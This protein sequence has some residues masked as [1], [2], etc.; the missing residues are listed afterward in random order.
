MRQERTGLAYHV[1]RCIEVE[2]GYPA[3]PVPSDAI[4][5]NALGRII[6]SSFGDAVDGLRE[7]VRVLHKYASHLDSLEVVDRLAGTL[8]LLAIS[9]RP[10]L[11]APDTGITALLE[12]L[13]IPASLHGLAALRDAILK[14]THLNLELTPAI[15][16]G[17]REHAAWES[18]LRGHQEKCLKWREHSR[19]ANL[20]YAPATHV[21]RR[22]LDTG[23]AL[24]APFD[25]IIQDQRSRIADVR[26]AME[27]WSSTRH[28]D[29][30]IT[31]T[32]RDIRGRGAELRPIEDLARTVLQKRVKEATDLFAA[33]ISLLEQE[34]RLGTDFRYKRASECR[35]EVIACLEKAELSAR[36]AREI[37]GN[38][39]L[40]IEVASKGVID[41]IVDLRN[42]FDPDASLIPDRHPREVLCKEL[43]AIPSLALDA[44]WN[45]PQSINVAD[46]LDLLL[47]HIESGPINWDRAFFDQLR[48]GN[49]DATER[50]L[51][52]IE[53]RKDASDDMDRLHREQER[54]IG[55]S[56]ARLGASLKMTRAAIERAIAEDLFA[57]SELI[58][59]RSIVDTV[60][61]EEVRNFA[62][63]EQQLQQV[64]T[65]IEYR[66]Q[67]R[68]DEVRERLRNN[69]VTIDLS[70]IEQALAKGNLLAANEYIAMIERGE[71]IQD[72]EPERDAFREFFPATAMAIQQFLTRE[73][74]TKREVVR[75]LGRRESV[76]P[77]D[78]TDVAEE[79]A[80][81]AKRMLAAWI[82]ASNYE[83]ADPAGQTRNALVELLQTLG[84]RNVQVSSV[85]A[86]A[87]EKAR[88]Y[89][90]QADPIVEQRTCVIPHYGSLAG[91]RYR[92][93]CVWKRPSEEELVDLA[94]SMHQHDR[95]LLV[96]Y[97]GN[98]SESRRRSLALLCKQ[99]P[100]SFLLVDENLIFFLATE[101]GLR[102]PSLFS[103]TFPFT[104]ADPYTTT[105]GLVPFEMFFGRRSERASVFEP[106]GT[107]LV[108]GGR[109]LGKT[110]LLRD[111]ERRHH[112]QAKG[113]IVRWIDLKAEGIGLNRPIGDLWV[114]IASVLNQEKVL[115]RHEFKP[116]GLGKAIEEWL[117]QDAKRRIVLLLDESDAFLK[118]DAETRVGPSHDAFSNLWRLKGIMDKTSRRFKVVFAGL[119]N[120]QRTSRDVN[121]PL[122]HLGAPICIGPLLGS[123]EWQEA[124]RMVT[125]PFSQLGYQFDATEDL[126]TRILALANWYPS[127]IQLFCKHLLEHLT[128]PNRPSFSVQSCP[129][130]VI[131]AKHIEDAYQ[132]QELRKAIVDRFR[133]TLDLDPRYR[134]IALVIALECATQRDGFIAGFSVQ[135]IREQALS[136]WEAGFR[137]TSS[138]EGLR[139]ILDEMIGLGVLRKVAGSNY[140]LRSPNVVNLL[141]TKEEIEHALIDATLHQPPPEYEASTFRRA[142]PGNANK[143]SPLTAKQESDLVVPSHGVSV[144]FGSKLA[145]LLDMLQVLRDASSAHKFD[146]DDAWDAVKSPEMFR[147]ML[148]ARTER[149]E[150]GLVV[151]VVPISCP[152]DIQWVIAAAEKLRSLKSTT[153]LVRVIFLAD[154]KKAWSWVQQ[155]T[156]KRER[157]NALGVSEMSLTPWHENAIRR[158][159]IDAGLGPGGG[160]GAE[161]FARATGSWGEILHEAASRC[162]KGLHQ[163]EKHLDDFEASIVTSRELLDRFEIRE[164]S[165][166][167]LKVLADM[168][169]ELNLDG[170]V[171]LLGDAEPGDLRQVMDWAELLSYVTRTGVNQWRIDHMVGHLLQRCPT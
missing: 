15:L 139:T 133:W 126:P 67:L 97:F 70:L 71:T 62:T 85:D 140:A 5:A 28:I 27:V 91:G 95:P 41:T 57:E 142:L 10:A 104:V 116:D 6:T 121:S 108:Y 16:K 33:W 76:G 136:W 101:K 105:A 17:V 80:E 43:L 20:I 114:I 46:F 170:L 14:F 18:L 143:R 50:I 169:S 93:L 130:Y 134:L 110:A 11:L 164:E 79:R 19:Q 162:E 96:L 159:L 106:T 3:S 128:H 88:T 107:C 153:K 158:W 132:S 141:G 125:M 34:P 47:A 36:S 111:V 56:H 119:H 122:A 90:V 118:S 150:G 92:V 25:N 87:S 61:T 137:S 89:N 42:L 124:R 81:E 155:D 55:E 165:L 171:D 60:R 8:L 167:A 83:G 39:R 54:A 109:Q 66:R 69:P 24:I 168:D 117:A 138:L 120:V 72:P 154:P 1:A 13:D 73:R 9:L 151:F 68:V 32:D 7:T 48:S 65:D 152:W 157:L 49:F 21:W 160:G 144:I 64:R 37:S 35:R 129:P 135:W 4:R 84:F 58:D 98:M 115:S 94:G 147:S 45:P 2:H 86:V 74:N 40:A 51:G 12:Q 38:H 63:I 100:R 163:W 59:R 102:L 127:L 156:A 148:S 78:M 75:A 161:R 77:L 113:L 146:L 82:Q 112:N 31:K 149:R 166:P 123:G 22:W 52:L 30:M 23:G 103:C 29:S 145:G 44:D 53:Q 99:R 131:T 26:R